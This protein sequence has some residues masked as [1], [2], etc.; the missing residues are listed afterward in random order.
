MADSVNRKEEV[1][2]EKTPGEAIGTVEASLRDEYDIADVQFAKASR[3]RDYWEVR[4][5]AELAGGED[6]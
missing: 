4:L 5:T 6:A 3:Y 1:S 2:L